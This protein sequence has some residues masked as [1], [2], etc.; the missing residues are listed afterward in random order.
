MLAPGDTVDRYTVIELL[1]SGGQASVWK[2]RERR[3]DAIVALKLVS[4]LGDTSSDRRARREAAVLASITHPSIVRCHRFFED[5]RRRVLGLVLE[6]VDGTTLDGARRDP[7]WTRAHLHAALTH[8][9]HGLAQ[10]HQAG[11]VHRDLKPS[12]VLVAQAFWDDPLDPTAIKIADLGI[13]AGFG[14]PGGLTTVGFIVGTG[15]FLA[16]ELLG[17]GRRDADAQPTRDVFAFGVL[18]WLLDRGVHPTGLTSGATSAE[19]ASIYEEHA[20]APALWLPDSPEDDAMTHTLRRC[21]R[22][23]PEERPRD[24]RALAT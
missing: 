14:N 1:G 20:E 13:A 12:N 3:S 21:L 18:G 2:A 6:W 22:L 9:A 23:R 4:L 19:L 7:R 24:G 10:L 11:V 16:P 5:A 15:P 17:A 8:V